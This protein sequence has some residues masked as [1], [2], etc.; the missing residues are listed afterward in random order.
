MLLGTPI[1]L[2]AEHNRLNMQGTLC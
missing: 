1:F 2:Q